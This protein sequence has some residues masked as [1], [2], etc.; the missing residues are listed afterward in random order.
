MF[1]LGGQ[2]FIFST[3]LMMDVTQLSI[4]NDC[5][6]YMYCYYTYFDVSKISTKEWTAIYGQ[7]E[8]STNQLQS[9]LLDLTGESK[10][11]RF[12]SV[13]THSV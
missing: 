10:L 13:S 3:L 4:Y 6:Y 12:G 9:L 2:C 8:K 5:F 1:S 7:A 11:Q